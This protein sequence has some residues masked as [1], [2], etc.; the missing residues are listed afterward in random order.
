MD[1]CIQDVIELR[2]LGHSWVK[3]AQLLCVS[4]STLYRRLHDH[5]ISPDDYS[6]LSISQLDE[7]VQNI[8]ADHPNDGE[9]LLK[10]HLLRLGL[11]VRR[12]DLRAS[13]HRIDHERT[14][15]RRSHTIN[16]RTYMVAAPNAMWHVDGN[17]KLIRWRFVIHA[18]VDGFSRII[19][20]IFCANNN[21]STTV[22]EAF[23]MGVS[24][25]GIPNCVRSDHG[26]ENV[27]IWRYM[28]GVHSE[29]DSCVL[30][31]SSTHNERVERLWR[32][33]NRCVSKQY[34]ELFQ[35]LERDGFLDP[36]N[37]VDIFS[38]HFTFLP[39]IN[40]CLIDFQ[41][42]WNNHGLSTEG[43]RTPYQLF[44]EGFIQEGTTPSF[45]STAAYSDSP[46]NDG[47][48]VVNVP[49]N[50]FKP[51]AVLLR[52]L[53]NVDTLQQ[54]TDH[55]RSIYI[56]VVHALGQHLPSCHICGIE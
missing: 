41:E 44:T 7:I 50:K 4:R 6:D 54:C 49:V 55:G 16:R 42:S 21:K 14:I 31:G 19:T 34:T 36:L 2:L 53:G 28:L 5:G 13:I 40:K 29:N 32:D 1:L 52:L 24:Q 23:S 22:L 11:K 15:E 35:S 51:C 46:S 37:E 25:F 10:G 20:Y 47:H 45:P 33:V 38:L 43:N 3:V 48:E 17:H 18:G 26:G 39:R 56:S 30:T 27:G 8:K 9:V 12:S